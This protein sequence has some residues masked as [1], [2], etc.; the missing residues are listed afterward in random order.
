[1]NSEYM[2]YIVIDD[3]N[4]MIPGYDG[5]VKIVK[6]DNLEAES[7]GYKDCILSL[8]NKAGS[9]DKAL[10]Y[11]N[12][13]SIDYTF[14]WFVEEDVFIPSIQSIKN[15]DAKYLT[16][17]LLSASNYIIHEKHTDWLW[18]TVNSQI[19]LN[20]PYACSMICAIRC[21]KKMLQSIHNY[22]TVHNRLFLDE[23]LFNTLA[24]HDMLETACPKELSSITYCHNWTYKNI[25]S[26][27]LYHPVKSI[28]QQYKFRTYLETG[29]IPD[30][31]SLSNSNKLSNQS[32]AINLKKRS[33]DVIL[34]NNK[35]VIHIN[36]KKHLN[37]KKKPDVI[38]FI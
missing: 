2:V 13:E 26:T 12:K 38:K 23:A 15:I 25:T 8:K 30:D 7:N 9:R 28:D 4:Y 27:H 29:T 20:L 36:Q 35:H 14:I 5:I 19:S 6:I 1:M 18:K 10:Y 24:L 33:A 17:D 11:F 34:I 32:S 16:H 3:N 22:A 37:S 31:I 21:S